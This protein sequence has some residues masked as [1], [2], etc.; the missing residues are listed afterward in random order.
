MCIYNTG[1]LVFSGSNGSTQTV[2]V[3]APLSFSKNVATVGQELT[4]DS[5]TLQRAGMYLVTVSASGSVSGSTAGVIGIQLQA[6]GQDVAGAYNPTTYSS[7]TGD[8]RNL[9]ITAVVPV[10]QTT[11]PLDDKS[12]TLTVVGTDN[13]AE[14]SDV[15]ITV[16]RLP[17]T[18]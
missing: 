17:W 13:A 5:V 7:S 12:V 2:A 15:M 14:F 1:N 8:V 9:T 11:C 6:N 16:A 18:R 10:Q 3:G 4:S